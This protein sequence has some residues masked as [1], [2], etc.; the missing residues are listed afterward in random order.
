MHVF[1]FKLSLQQFHAAQL[2]LFSHVKAG[3]LYASS[4]HPRREEPPQ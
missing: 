2:L 1:S 4:M 3:D